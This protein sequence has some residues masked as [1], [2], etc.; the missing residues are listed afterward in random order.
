MKIVI[1]Y[2]MSSSKKNLNLLG[3]AACCYVDDCDTTRR[4][5]NCHISLINVKIDV[6]KAKQE[7]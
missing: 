7:I 2:L 6:L 1:E 3:R 5:H 4:E